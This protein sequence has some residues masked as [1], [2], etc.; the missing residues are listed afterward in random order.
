MPGAG[1]QVAAAPSSGG[2]G[3]PLR[4]RVSPQGPRL[5]SRTQ[6]MNPGVGDR[7]LGCRR[8]KRTWNPIPRFVP[9]LPID[10]NWC[11]PHWRFFV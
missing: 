1:R 3:S 10:P 5:I 9:S 2:P 6:L 11:R 8:G 7:G 4:G